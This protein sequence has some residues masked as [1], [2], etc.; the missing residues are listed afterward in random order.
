MAANLK[1]MSR[2]ANIFSLPWKLVAMDREINTLTD[3]G[4]WVL[5]EL[6]VGLKWVLKVNTQADG[7]RD[8]FKAQLV[9][10]ELIYIKV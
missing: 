7:T 9:A 1:R 10:K 5:Q 6:V 2:F 3:H 8:K 4:T